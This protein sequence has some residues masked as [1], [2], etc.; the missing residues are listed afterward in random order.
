MNYGSGNVGNQSA[1]IIVRG[2]ST[3]HIKDKYSLTYIVHET[4]IGFLLGAITGTLGLR[5]GHF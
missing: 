1:T 2:I 4:I 3:G 5:Y